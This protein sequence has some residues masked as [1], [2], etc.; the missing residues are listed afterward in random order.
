MRT[1]KTGIEY[2]LSGLRR[3]N[4][5]VGEGKRAVLLLSL[6]W[7][8]TR[9]DPGNTQVPLW[10][11]DG[12]EGYPRIR[13]T[14]LELFRELTRKGVTIVTGS[15]NNDAV[16][17]SGRRCLKSAKRKPLTGLP[18]QEVDGLPASLGDSTAAENDRLDE[19]IVLGATNHESTERWVTYEGLQGSN[20]DVAKRLPHL[21]APGWNVKCTQKTVD[22]EYG[23]DQYRD[24]TGTSDGG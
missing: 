9:D 21:C 13:A 16:S 8:K 18:Q 3:I 5:D 24:S 14:M 1:P 15:G 4:D 7:P 17:L 12:V 23:H 19:L 2:Y 20:R 22:P 10:E 6:Y 11:K